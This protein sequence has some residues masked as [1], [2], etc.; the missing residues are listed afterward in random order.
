LSP[1]GQGADY[2]RI[3]AENP[4]PYTLE[5]TNTWI[6]G[7]DPAYVIDPGPALDGHIAAIVREVAGR[8]GLGAVL[9]THDHH[10]HSDGVGL[11]R[12]RLPAPLAAARGAVEVRLGDGD[13]LGPLQAVATPG[14]APDHLAFVCE[15]AC[16]TGDAVLGAGS[17]F[18]APL[19][20]AMAAYL[21]GLR[22]LRALEP[23]VLCPGHGPTV[24]DPVAK[25]E[26]Y[27]AH[28]EARERRL[29][30]ALADGRRSVEEL[31]DAAWGEVPGALRTAAAVTL[32]AH[33]DKLAG[34]GRLVPG[35]ERRR[36][37]W[38]EAGTAG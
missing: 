29:V 28:R 36:Y 21:D 33:L 13:R 10:D 18:V 16:F 14:H 5:G 17:V 9:L 19:P 12:E 35:V 30:A 8:G 11:L 15:R 23:A 2:A 6:V 37:D 25:L 26:E 22:R 4:G 3:R 20:G 38:P 1:A 32:E 24:E 7:R 34:E 31:L 27:L